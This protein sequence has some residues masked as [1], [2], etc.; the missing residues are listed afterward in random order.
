MTVHSLSQARFSFSVI[1][2]GGIA[3]M[4]QATNGL[5]SARKILFNA[6]SEGVRTLPDN[7][8]LFRFLSTV[9]SFPFL[10]FLISTRRILGSL[11]VFLIVF[12]V[13]R[14][15]ALIRL[16]LVKVVI[17]IVSG[18]SVFAAMYGRNCWKNYENRDLD[19]KFS[20]FM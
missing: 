4:D 8:T 18:E 20:I 2:T 17:V 1:G 3:V 12:L 13:P 9:S 15:R 10:R 19:D 7:F 11:S 16:L 6:S 14:R 5:P